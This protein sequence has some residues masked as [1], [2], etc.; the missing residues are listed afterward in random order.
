MLTG[1]L[2]FCF[3]VSLRLRIPGVVLSVTVN[4]PGYHAA[5]HQ[6]SKHHH[7][8]QLFPVC[9]DECPDHTASTLLAV[10]YRARRS[11]MPFFPPLIICVTRT[12]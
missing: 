12:K 5:D 11:S 8:K 1:F 4:I 10:M 7:D 6:S 2:I 3:A 9:F